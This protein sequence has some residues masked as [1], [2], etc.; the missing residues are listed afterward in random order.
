MGGGCES[1]PSDL[2]A[3]KVVSYKRPTPTPTPANATPSRTRKPH[4]LALPCRTH[5]GEGGGARRGQLLQRQEVRLEE[6][7]RREGAVEGGVRDGATDATD[8]GATAGGGRRDGAVRDGDGHRHQEGWGTMWGRI[9]R[10]ERNRKSSSKNNFYV[11]LDV[12][13][14]G[15]DDNTTPLPYPFSPH[16]TSG[17]TLPRLSLLWSGGINRPLSQRPLAAPTTHR[18]ARPCARCGPRR[19]AA[20]APS[21]TRGSA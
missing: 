5:H 2:C 6:L 3:G 20:P 14:I 8:R 12:M 18:T 11:D 15:D 4:S 19:M 9:D 7:G 17:P 13:L 21:A 1:P 16:A 10:A